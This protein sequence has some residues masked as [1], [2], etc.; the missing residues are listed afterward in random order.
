METNCLTTRQALTSEPNTRDS[1]VLQHI[2]SCADCSEFSKK[3]KQFDDKLKSAIQLD[4]PEGLESKIILAQRMN[5]DETSEEGGNDD[6]VVAFKKPVEKQQRNFQW[7]SMAAALVLA[8]GLSLG[9]FKWGESQGVQH[10]VLA[11]IDSHLEELEKDEN[12]K[13]ASLNEFLEE[14]GLTANEGIGYVRHVSNCPIEG[15]MIPHLVVA[16]DQ[17]MP[18][19]VMYIPWEDAKQTK[20]FSNERFKGIS[21]GAQKGS[22]VI[23]SEYEDS[24]KPIENRVMESMEIDI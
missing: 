20:R 23:V 18:V 21:V 11:H 22:F 8:V 1:E 3:L 9:M 7:M 2:A 6:N 24:L 13:L 17:G 14:H 12:V 10:E 16:D 19:T 4:V 15:R 5:V